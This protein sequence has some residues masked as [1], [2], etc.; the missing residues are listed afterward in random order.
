MRCLDLSHFADLKTSEI[1]TLEPGNDLSY[2]VINK[3]M[4]LLVDNKPRSAA[5]TCMF[6]EDRCANEQPNKL[7][8]QWWSL[9]NIF[10]PICVQ[11]HWSLL[12]ASPQ[13]KSISIAN[14]KKPT[15]QEL[16]CVRLVSDFLQKN[17]PVALESA[18]W[19]I[20]LHEGTPVQKHGH[21]SGVFVCMFAR[22]I[23]YRLR[24]FDHSCVQVY[25]EW[26][27]KELFNNQLYN[28]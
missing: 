22:Q 23:L 9:Q 7:P 16:K 5:L 20:Y 11:S 28:D 25:R 2:A 27:K 24:Q 3:Y 26:M 8:S 14:S 6:F 15:R 4:E 13:Q 12:C 21:D 18:S 1:Q 17:S 19:S 10:I